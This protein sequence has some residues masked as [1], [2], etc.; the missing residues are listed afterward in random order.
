MKKF[1]LEKS[2]RLYPAIYYYNGDSIACLTKDNTCHMND[3]ISY[4]GHYSYLNS[5]LR[6]YC[7]KYYQVNEQGIRIQVDIELDEIIDGLIILKKK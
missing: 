1:L 6:Y 5:K 2:Y 4:R 3:R 7:W